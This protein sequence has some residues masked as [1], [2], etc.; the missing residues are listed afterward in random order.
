VNSAEAALGLA[1]RIASQIT[2]TVAECRVTLSA[3]IALFPEHG[4]NFEELY[5]A[6]D[7]ALYKIKKSGKAACAL[8]VPAQEMK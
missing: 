7:A 5:K 4:K 6:A 3:G 8:Y 1:E 2:E